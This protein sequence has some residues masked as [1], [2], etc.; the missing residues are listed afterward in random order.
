MVTD[1]IGE[2]WD[3]TY[4]RNLGVLNL[5]SRTSRSDGKGVTPRYD[6][7]N[8]LVS[9]TDAEGRT[10]VFGLDDDTPDV[11]LKTARFVV[12]EGIDLPRFAILTPFPGTPLFRQLK[13]EGRIL[14]EDWSL[15]D[16]QHVVFQP[17]KMSVEQL[18]QGT[19]AAWE[20]T[21]RYASIWRRLAGSRREPLRALAANLGYRYYARHLNQFYTCSTLS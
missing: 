4:E 16:G 2:L 14:T 1:P 20:Y 15:Y 19:A 12:E 10:T 18:V 3:Y 13:D 11:F 21:Y 7:N 6:V 5:I 17:L 9:S 8:N